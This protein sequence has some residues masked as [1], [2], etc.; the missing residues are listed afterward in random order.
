MADIYESLRKLT[1]T[2]TELTWNVTCQKIFN[3][4]KSIIKGYT[5]MK[6]YDEIKPLYLE[7]DAS[8]VELGATLLQTKS[9]TNCPSD[10]PPNNSIPRPIAF[11]SKNLTGL[12]KKVQQHRKR[13]P[14]HI[15]WTWKFHHYCFIQKVSIITDH[16]NTSHNIQK[17]YVN[18]YHYKTWTRFVNSRLTIKTKITMKT[19]MQKY[20][21]CS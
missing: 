20:M 21:A 11:T 7:M 9:S 2:K 13:S 15:I 3:K 19:K 14:M 18:F 10:D 16:K 1:S 12:K 17:G 6:F 8:G 4:A 5:R